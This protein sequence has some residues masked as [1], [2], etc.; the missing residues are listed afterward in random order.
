MRIKF[1]PALLAFGIA[2]FIAAYVMGEAQRIADENAS[3][4]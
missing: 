4:L 3:I 1:E 2:T